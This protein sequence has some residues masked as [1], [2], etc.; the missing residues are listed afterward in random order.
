L[1][2]WSWDHL[3]SKALIRESPDRVFVWNETQKREAV[4]LHGIAPERVVVT[5]AQCFDIWFDREPARDRETFCRRV[6]FPA[7]RPFILYVCSALFL[8]SPPEQA[9]VVEWIRRVRAS[10][11]PVLRSAPILV[12]PHPSRMRQWEGVDLTS[13][14]DV[15][16]WGDRP[17]DGSSRADYFDS[18]YHSAAVVGLNTTAFIEA[19]ITGRPV[20][21]VLLP[22]F[23]ENQ[24]GTIHFRYL[25]EAGGG[26]LTVAPD[27][28]EH[29]RQLADAL[30]QPTT[31]VRPFVREFVRPHGVSVT[32]TPLFVR[33]VEAMAGLCAAAAPIDLFAPVCRW[34]AGTLLRMKRA[35]RYEQWVYSRRELAQ[36]AS[37]REER[38]RK[39]RIAAER[40]AAAYAAKTARR[41]A[42]R[43]A[44]E[45][46]RRLKAAA[47]A[48]KKA[49]MSSKPGETSI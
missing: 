27:F 2:V 43:R 33:Q 16:L 42:R 9:F 10:S 18:L 6:G 31:M 5:G 15:A 44:W 30:A 41:E 3:S 38:A 7:D 48:Q 14:G 17:L 39:A 23:F 8:G 12:R 35:G 20:Y 28:D 29:L 36:M 34:L 46:H 19:A 21:T 32:A 45:R 40:K 13:F 24:M 26:L 22:E 49:R 1:C 25:L 11:S 4:E 37:I 47:D